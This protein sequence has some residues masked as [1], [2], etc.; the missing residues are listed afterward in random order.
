MGALNNK[1]LQLLKLTRSVEGM[2]CWRLLNMEIDVPPYVIV[3]LWYHF[4]MS[5]CTLFDKEVQWVIPLRQ[6][7]IASLSDLTLAKHGLRTFRQKKTCEN[8]RQI[9]R[10]QWKTWVQEASH[11]SPAKLYRVTHEE[12]RLVVIMLQAGLELTRSVRKKSCVAP[13]SVGKKAA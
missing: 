8:D 11:F 3:K 13:R 1:Q 4:Q 7:D 6:A 2:E 10:F 12:T 9:R 5:S